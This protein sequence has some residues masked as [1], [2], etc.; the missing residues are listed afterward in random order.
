MSLQAIERYIDRRSSESKVVWIVRAVG[1]RRQGLRPLTTPAPRANVTSGQA[2]G[3]A[4][5]LAIPSIRDGED[6]LLDT[7]VLIADD[8]VHLPDAKPGAD[9]FRDSSGFAFRLLKIGEPKPHLFKASAI[10]SDT[11]IVHRH[12]SEMRDG[13]K[14][15]FPSHDRHTTNYLAGAATAG[16]RKAMTARPRDAEEPRAPPLRCNT[17]FRTKNQPMT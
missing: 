16:S 7:L 10:P 3:F 2:T 13:G 1:P 15:F 8:N 6:F 14:C 11:E 12:Y 17:P 4:D 5:G 9:F